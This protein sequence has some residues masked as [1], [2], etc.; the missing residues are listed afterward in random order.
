M[1]PLFADMPT[2]IFEA[3]SG[4]ARDLGAVNLGQGFPD[5]GWPEDVIAR[6]AEA[7]TKGSN[8]YP[9][10][11]GLP[12]LREAVA[13]HY[14]RHQGLKID[15]SQVIVT[16]GATEALAA[17]LLALIAP[18]DEVVL[19][20]PLYDAYLPLVLRAGGVPRLVRLTPPD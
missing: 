4:A 16:S 7:L 17:S 1:N 2:T 8:Q 13:G 3:M 6:A 19:I 5:F 15:P 12:E 11:R 10:M 14:R 18:G 9:P 20:Q